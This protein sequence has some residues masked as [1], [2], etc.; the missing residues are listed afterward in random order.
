M[1]TGS[2]DFE[3]FKA[4]VRQYV[5]ELPGP[6]F[7]QFVIETR[8]PDEVSAAGKEHAHHG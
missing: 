3:L 8:P 6:E 2:E 7:E 5:R 1:T 4:A